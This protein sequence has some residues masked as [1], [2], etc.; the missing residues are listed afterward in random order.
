MLAKLTYKNQLT[1]PKNV[2]KEFS[3]VQYFDVSSEGKE[4]ILRPV[5]VV[6]SESR[7]SAVR[8]KI[9]SLGLTE[10]DIDGAIQWARNKD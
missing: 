10:E 7:L 1:L 3:G 5:S 9:K 6:P 2:L 8:E 4:I